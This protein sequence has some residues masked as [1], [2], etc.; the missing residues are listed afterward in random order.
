MARADLGAVKIQ[1]P[2]NWP[3]M[4][5]E[6]KGDFVRIAPQGGV[7]KNGVGYGV[8][9]SGTRPA[10]GQ[11]VGIDEMTRR[12]IE[13]IQ[14]GNEL[15][16]VDEPAPITVGGTESRSTFLESPSPFPDAEGR[17]QKE[18]DWLVTVPRRDGSLIFMIFV[19]PAADFAQFQPTYEAMVRSVQLK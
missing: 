11:R 9:L 19:A 17:P 12:V 8:L 6:Q 4:L 7:T 1:H 18:R 15:Q 5:P 14:E 16:P 13:K 10:P 3:V 2:E